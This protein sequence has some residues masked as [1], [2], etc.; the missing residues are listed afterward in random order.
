[1]RKQRLCRRLEDL[2]KTSVAAAVQRAR[3]ASVYRGALDKLWARVHAWHADPQNQAW[4]EAQPPEFLAVRV[5]ELRAKLWET[6]NGHRGGV[7]A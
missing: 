2:E 3:A 4:V 1:M 7:A 6:A 5:Q